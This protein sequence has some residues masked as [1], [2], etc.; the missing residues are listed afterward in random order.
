MKKIDKFAFSHLW[1]TW[2]GKQIVKHSG[3]PF[4]S[5]FKVGVVKDIMVNPYSN[6][7]AF[8]MDDESLVDCHQCKLHEP[9]IE[10]I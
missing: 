9:Q 3:K 6:K 10:T 2:V 7:I 8:L 4:K 5:T 1:Q